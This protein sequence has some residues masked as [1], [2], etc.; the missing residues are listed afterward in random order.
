MSSIGSPRTW[1]AVARQ[2]RLALPAAATAALFA[3][4]SGGFFPDARAG[5]AGGVPPAAARRRPDHARPPPVRG[6]EPGIAVCAGAVGPARGVDAPLGGLVR[7]A[8][9]GD[10]RVR[11]RPRVH[12]LIVGLMGSYGACARR[13]GPGGLRGTVAFVLCGIGGG[14]ARAPASEPGRPCRSPRAPSRRGSRSRS[15]TGTGSGI[16]SAIGI[17]LLVHLTTSLREPR[18]VRVVAAALCPVVVAT[19]YFTFSRGG[20]AAAAD[21]DRGRA[22]ARRRAGRP[23]HRDA[24]R[25]RRL[26]GGG[27][28]G[29]RRRRARGQGLQVAAA[30]VAERP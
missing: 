5:A 9:A 4:R 18:A 21:R 16:T 29:A 3:F 12:A 2:A 7:R 28:R 14:R 26:G 6:L 23:A 8:A 10:G 17:V 11:P 19:A 30:G 27:A 25:G 1:S 22:G 20:I 15:P 24:A 13:P